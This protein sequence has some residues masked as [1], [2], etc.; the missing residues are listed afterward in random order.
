MSQPTQ[1]QQTHQVTILTLQQLLAELSEA[2]LLN[3]ELG[4]YDH[5]ELLVWELDEE[6]IPNFCPKT[7][8]PLQQL[9]WLYTI[10]G[11]ILLG[12]WPEN[13]LLGEHFTAW[14]YPEY[15]HPLKP[16]LSTAVH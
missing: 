4:D 5:Y 2:A 16:I 10:T 11:N 15:Q 14:A 1:P 7:H 13:G 3:P 9:L 8:K 6:P 12:H